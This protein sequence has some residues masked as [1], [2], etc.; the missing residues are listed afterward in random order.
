MS[1]AAGE[2]DTGGA[3]AETW[4][5]GCTGAWLRV[6]LWAGMQPWDRAGCPFSL[7]ISHR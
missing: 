2:P 5:L 1:G 4:V 7:S 3:E 6:V